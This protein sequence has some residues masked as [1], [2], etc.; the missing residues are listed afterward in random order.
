MHTTPESLTMIANVLTLITLLF[1]LVLSIPAW[2]WQ[3]FVVSKLWN[4]FVV[5]AMNVPTIGTLRA[6]G[7]TLIAF[8]L[9]PV[10]A[11]GAIGEG[12]H[13]FVQACMLTVG[14]FLWPLLMLACGGLVKLFDSN[15]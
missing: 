8:M 2:V 12:W 3:G 7:L 15:E 6:M 14:M 9:V 13:G 1:A 11:Y 10:A 5:P 4:W